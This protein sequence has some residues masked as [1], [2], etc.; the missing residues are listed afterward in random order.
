MCIILLALDVHPEYKLI[1]L[2]N[3]DEFYNRPTAPLA[4]WDDFPDLLAGRDLKAGGTWLGVT[5][6]G[7]I[8]ALTNFRDPATRKERAPSRGNLLKRFL[9]GKESASAFLQ[10]LQ[11]KASRYNGFN[12]L[13]GDLEKIFWYSNRGRG[14]VRLKPGIYGLSNHLLDTPWPKVTWGKEALKQALHRPRSPEPSSL[15]EIL[16]SRRIPDDELLPDTG[17]GIEWE[18]LL[19]PIFVVSPKYGTRASSILLIDRKHRGIFWEESFG[20]DGKP[21]GTHRYTFQLMKSKIRR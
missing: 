8:G 9:T 18:R 3:R 11:E 13:I 19:A 7:R 1:L 2:S 14:A 6:G 12:F 10:N 20:S 4:F 17:V 21:L 5:L 16:H 15:L